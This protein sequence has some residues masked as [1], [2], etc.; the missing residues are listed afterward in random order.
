MCLT[1]SPLCLGE[2][3]PR[4]SW[5]TSRH[6]LPVAIRPGAPHLSSPAAPPFL[7]GCGHKGKALRRR[8]GLCQKCD[9]GSPWL[10]T[11]VTPRTA[12][13]ERIGFWGWLAHWGG[14]TEQGLLMG[15]KKCLV[16]GARRE[17]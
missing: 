11:K 17:L 12:A 13:V 6:C 16:T 1:E 3:W 7:T 9:P 5:Q 10:K 8:P 15:R 4:L 14:L 2:G